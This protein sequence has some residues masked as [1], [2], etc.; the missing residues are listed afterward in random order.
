MVSD[1]HDSE[2]VD[3]ISATLRALA[4]GESVRQSHN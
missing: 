3:P 4:D 1:K 2:A